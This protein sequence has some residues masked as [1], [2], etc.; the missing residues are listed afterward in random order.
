VFVFELLEE[1]RVEIDL[2]TVCRLQDMVS[3]SGNLG[4]TAMVLLIRGTRYLVPE[5]RL[6]SNPESVRKL[7]QC[8][9][10]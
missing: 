6:S 4:S 10:R 2:E 3:G 7:P 8:R 1:Q 5:S 9:P